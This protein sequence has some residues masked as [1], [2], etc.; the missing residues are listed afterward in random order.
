MMRT[1]HTLHVCC[2][3]LHAANVTQ[4]GTVLFGEDITTKRN[5]KRYK[6]NAERVLNRSNH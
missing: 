6:T 4:T 1:R 3:G 5:I 2:K